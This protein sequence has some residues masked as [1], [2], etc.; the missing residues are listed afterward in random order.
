MW[1]D[2]DVEGANVYF[3]VGDDDNDFEIHS[4]QYYIA[5]NDRISLTDAR[6][7]SS[8][9]KSIPIRSCINTLNLSGN[10]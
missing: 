1:L 9:T 7:F 8:L 5:G 4:S 2:D 3:G 10:G 6:C